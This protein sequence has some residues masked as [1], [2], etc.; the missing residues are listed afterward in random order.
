MPSLLDLI[1]R[2][3][4][5]QK[6]KKKRYFYYIESTSQFYDEI[7]NTFPLKILKAQSFTNLMVMVIQGTIFKDEIEI[8]KRFLVK[9]FHITW[10]V[11]AHDWFYSLSKK[12]IQLFQELCALFINKYK[13]NARK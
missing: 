13:C 6:E 7:H 8:N 10:K 2:I 5:I 11:N 9:F 1:K 3:D 12:L 4:Q